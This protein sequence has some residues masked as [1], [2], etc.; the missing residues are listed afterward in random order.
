M[1]GM[2][3]HLVDELIK[4]KKYS[5]SRTISFVLIEI[6]AMTGVPLGM[7][8]GSALFTFNEFPI[9]FLTSAIIN[10]FV[11]IL[12]QFLIPHNKTLEKGSVVLESNETRN[13]LNRYFPPSEGYIILA[14]E[15]AKV[16]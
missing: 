7:L 14:L 8:V 4:R 13:Q 11:F 3:A 16:I 1:I 15:I 9:T 6:F 5:N 12:S 2:M 10:V